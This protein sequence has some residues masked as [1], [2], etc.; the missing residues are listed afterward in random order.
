MEKK[1]NAQNIFVAKTEVKRP[2]RRTRYGDIIK[3]DHK[4]MG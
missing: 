2:F 1:I 3:M 4:E